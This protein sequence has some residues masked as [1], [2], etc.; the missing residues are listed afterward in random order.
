MA[1]EKNRVKKISNNSNLCDQER[2]KTKHE[3]NLDNS[4]N[5]IPNYV[6]FSLLQC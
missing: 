2:N 4:K 5:N 3:K 6:F 1:C